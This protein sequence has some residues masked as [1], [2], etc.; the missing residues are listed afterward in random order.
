MTAVRVLFLC[1]VP[2]FHGGAERVLMDMLAHPGLVPHLCVPAAGEVAAAA[3]ARGVPVSVV[4][5]RRVAAVHRPVRPASLATAARDAARA[6]RSVRALARE[7]G[8]DVV[9]SNG[10]KPHVVAA[11][12]RRSGPTPWRFVAHLH[13]IPYTPLERAIWRGIVAAADGVVAVSRPCVPNPDARHVHIIPNGLELPSRL[14]AR[15]LGRPLRIGFIG[16]YAK[17]KGLHLL[18]DW[19]EAARADGVD[20]V[21]KLRG[22]T[23]PADAAYWAEVKGR[24]DASPDAARI[25]DEGFRPRDRLYDE[26][27]VVA[28]S[29][30]FPDP[31]PFVVKEAQVEGVPVIGYPA[32]GIP[33]MIRDGE[34]GFLAA[35]P[36]AFAGAVRRLRDEAGLFESVRQGAWAHA[37]REFPMARFHE[38]LLAVYR[39]LQPRGAAAAVG[40]CE[41]DGAPRQVSRRF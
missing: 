41:A 35:T 8:C 4:D 26:L 34:T 25:V 40:P 1:P 21:L 15:R 16:R 36:A 24:I 10:L 37:R 39:G 20:A 33:D 22:R 28:V 31:H 38:R 18:L 2:D 32:G 14:P 7:V 5:F 30:D 17:F 11:I 27:D 29:S 23:S 3:A 12:A 13:D 9:H 19:F 6:A